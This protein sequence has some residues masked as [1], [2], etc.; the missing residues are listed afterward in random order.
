[1]TDEPTDRTTDD[2][3][4]QRNEPDS[5]C[6]KVCVMHPEAG[7]CIGCYRTIDEISGWAARSEQE[8]RDI[9]ASLDQRAGLLRGRRQGRRPARERAAERARNTRDR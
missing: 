6:V 5:P 7:I 2:G 8:R 3:V 9:R 1:M 4:W